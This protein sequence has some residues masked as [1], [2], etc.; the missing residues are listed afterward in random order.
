MQLELKSFK[1]KNKTYTQFKDGHFTE[2]KFKKAFTLNNGQVVAINDAHEL[3]L[4]DTGAII[5]PNIDNETHIYER[6]N[7]FKDKKVFWKVIESS[8]SLEEQKLKWEKFGNSVVQDSILEKLRLSF[9]NF[10]YYCKYI[11]VFTGYYKFDI[12]AI[13]D[14][15]KNMYEDYKE[16][17]SMREF[18]TLKFGE[19]L[20][21]QI[22]EYF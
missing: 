19:D 11:K 12:V 10:K 14:A 16:G 18:I 4:V 2:R 5:F 7:N 17:M 3:I 20:A 15:L 22:T 6:Y 8:P 13:D 21:N 9:N 1:T